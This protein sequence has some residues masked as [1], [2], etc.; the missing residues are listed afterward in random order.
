[1]FR[2]KVGKIEPP[3]FILFLTKEKEEKKFK[4]GGCYGWHKKS[5]GRAIKE[6]RKSQEKKEKREKNNREVGPNY[7]DK[8]AK[9]KKKKK[10][11]SP[12]R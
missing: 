7:K 1:M 5:N 4:L 9:E 6:K 10:K 3:F 2:K 8:K 12:R 11:K